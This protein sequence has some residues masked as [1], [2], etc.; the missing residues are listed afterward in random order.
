MPQPMSAT[1][2]SSNQ[3]GIS[4]VEVLVA[5]V[6]GMFSVLIMISLMTNFN[7]QQ[8]AARGMDDALVNALLGLHTMEQDLRVAGHGLAPNELQ[9][10]TQ[11]F[12]YYGPSAG[13]SAA[14]I[15][16]FATASLQITDGGGGNDSLML[17]YAESIR[18]G[19]PANL[20]ANMS[21]PSADL[22]VDT[23]F[24]FSVNGLVLV[25]NAAGQ[26]ALRQV[27][28]VA[29][30]SPYVL[31]AAASGPATYNPP[32]GVA[33]GS[34]TWPTYNGASSAVRVYAL[35]VLT[36]R[37]YSLGTEGLVVRDMHATSDTPVAAD[38][39]GLQAQYGISASVGS[40]TV[41]QWVDA[42]GG[43]AS[44]SLADRKR[45]VAVRVA[46]VA[47]SSDR[48]PSEVSPA[49]LELWPAATTGQLSAAQ[50]YTVP[51]RNYRYR[52]LRTVVPLKNLMWSNLS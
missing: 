17:R 21:S 40:T 45:I 13:T 6:I 36:M 47:R 46:L 31:T 41:T 49:A 4:L 22:T 7:A 48:A 51:D 44:P 12:S 8:R 42:T 20:V 37:R 34:P 27:T 52:V 25:S 10:C 16:D 18:G 35:G 50:S 11:F 9:N 2:K 28:A 33:S 1:R 14:P 29:S 30:S 32:S 19:Q 39:V 5:L 15:A 24:G 38:V 23:P 3:R 26:C 43:W